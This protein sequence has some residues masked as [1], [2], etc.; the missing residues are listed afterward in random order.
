MSYV[1]WFCSVLQNE[2]LCRSDKQDLSAAVTA[3]EASRS[4]ITASKSCTHDSDFLSRQEVTLNSVH[5][6][7][8]ASLHAKDRHISSLQEKVRCCGNQELLSLAVR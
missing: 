5:E 2:E 6:K 7:L 1:E 4:H 8:E 3:C